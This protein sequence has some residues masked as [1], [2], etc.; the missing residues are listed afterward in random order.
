MEDDFL[1]ELQRLPHSALVDLARSQGFHADILN[2]PAELIDA[3]LDGTPLTSR[4]QEM[5]S[6]LHDYIGRQKA[7]FMDTMDDTCRKCFLKGQT[8]CSDARAL[9]DYLNNKQYLE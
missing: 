6:A 3:I 9:M 1:E 5:R 4:I 7:A 2:T 8:A